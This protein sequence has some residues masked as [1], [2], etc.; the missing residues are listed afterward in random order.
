MLYNEKYHVSAIRRGK[1]MSKSL[2][3][4]VVVTATGLVGVV[5]R[6]AEETTKAFIG[7]EK[8]DPVR[9]HIHCADLAYSKGQ[10]Q[11][12]SIF[13]LSFNRSSIYSIRI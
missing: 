3:G 1:G 13:V 5:I 12:Q 9:S 4:A 10:Y 7:V 6:S 8:V 11:L 2:E